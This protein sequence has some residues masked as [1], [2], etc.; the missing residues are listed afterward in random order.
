MDAARAVARAVR[1]SS[2]GLPGIKALAFEVNGEAQ[3][4]MNLV[5][6]EHT[7]LAT[8]FEAVRT[9]AER[10]GIAPTR[11]ELVGLVPE[12]ALIEAGARA[13][14]LDDFRPEQVLEHQLRQRFTSRRFDDA[15]DSLAAPTPSPGG[16]TAA[17][18]AGAL[19]AALTAM[20]AGITSSRESGAERR[21]A[22][23]EAQILLER[24]K[25]LAE[26]DAAAYS[27]FVAESR[28]SGERAA[29]RR[30]SALLAAARVPL[31]TMRA[32]ARIASL[33]AW[34]AER[35]PPAAKS[36][37][38]AA[39][40]LAEAACRAAAITVRANLAALPPDHPGASDLAAQVQLPLESAAAAL[41]AVSS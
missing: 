20:V 38:A 13:L 36:D 25:S 24:L 2:G 8:A 12:R 31:E 39:V 32:C 6:L 4:S 7:S 14:R 17:A 3:L 10:H 33:A 30:A 22:A 23:E 21:A 34:I 16:G 18:L 27:A 41:L 29:D 26:R 15:L 28:L 9:E 19:G 37:A 35:C 40:L 11:G 1:E 5:D